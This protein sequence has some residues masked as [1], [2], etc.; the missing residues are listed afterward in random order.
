[1]ESASQTLKEVLEPLELSE[2]RVP[3]YA[4]FNA[5]PYTQA[6]LQGAAGGPG[7]EPGAL[8]GN[9]GAAVRAGVDTF[10]ECGPGKTLCGLIRKTV[11]G[12][13]V[14]NVQDEGNPEGGSGGREG[15]GLNQPEKPPRGVLLIVAVK[16]PL[17]HHF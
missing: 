6:A 8:A 3:V 13:T 10:I 16:R 9:R 2:A 14:L 17:F 4:N 7:E 11:K 15:P 12:V 1:M 5:Q